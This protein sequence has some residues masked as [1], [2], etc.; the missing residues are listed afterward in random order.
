ML[1]I[2]KTNDGRFLNLNTMACVVTT[3]PTK[4]R[5]AAMTIGFAAIGPE[6]CMEIKLTDPDDMARLTR[7]LS[8]AA[9][10]LESQVEDRLTRTWPKS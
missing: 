4:G 10:D 9:K 1:R 2:F 5:F 6:D 3:S 8:L 7:I